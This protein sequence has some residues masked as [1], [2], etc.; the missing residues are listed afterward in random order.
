M[1]E[2]LGVVGRRLEERVR[3][4]TNMR[5]IRSQRI[6][7]DRRQNDPS[8]HKEGEGAGPSVPECSNDR[9]GVHS[10]ASSLMRTDRNL[11]CA[12]Q[13]NGSN[14]T[15]PASENIFL[16]FKKWKLS[17][18]YFCRAHQVQMGGFSARWQANAKTQNQMWEFL[19]QFPSRS[20]RRQQFRLRL[21]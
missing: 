1:I 20:S 7:E 16:F 15:R 4:E 18:Q 10:I 19:F 8:S 2:A 3:T 17:L 6:T 13:R 9:L 14:G 5:G 21:I 12:H 11:G